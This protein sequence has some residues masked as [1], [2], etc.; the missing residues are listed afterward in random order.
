MANENLWWFAEYDIFLEVP[1]RFSLLWRHI[2]GFA[3][4]RF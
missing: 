2:N 4:F 3:A 1:V